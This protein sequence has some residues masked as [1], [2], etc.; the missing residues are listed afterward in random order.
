M[1]QFLLQGYSNLNESESRV[2]LI[3]TGLISHLSVEIAAASEVE[4]GIPLAV[5]DIHQIKPITA[6][7]LDKLKNFDHIVIL[8][9]SYRSTL[10]SELAVHISPTIL[11]LEH[12]DVEWNERACHNRTYRKDRAN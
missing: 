11:E 6:N 5:I 7:L 12:A 1:A 2:L 4:L 9:E 3:S 8:E 10:A